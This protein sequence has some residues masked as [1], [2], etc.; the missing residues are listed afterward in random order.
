MKTF[1][2]AF[3][4]GFP[5]NL[6]VSQYPQQRLQFK[7]LCVCELRSIQDNAKIPTPLK[8][9]VHAQL[10]PTKIYIQMHAHIHTPGITVHWSVVV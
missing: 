7:S 8:N 10:T 3:L 6:T 9:Y 1:F 2:L 4:S 5:F